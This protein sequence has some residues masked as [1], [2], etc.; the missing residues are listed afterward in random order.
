MRL[1]MILV[2]AVAVVAAHL[3]LQD[4]GLARV[5]VLGHTPQAMLA[6]LLPRALALGV[7]IGVTAMVPGLVAR[8]IALARLRRKLQE[9]EQPCDDVG[10]P[11]GKSGG[12][13]VR[14]C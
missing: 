8:S 13:L 7:L 12:G 4:T 2:V 9:C 1:A 5:M 11:A 6:V 3:A 14:A 10:Q